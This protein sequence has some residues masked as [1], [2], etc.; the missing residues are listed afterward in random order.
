MNEGLVAAVSDVLSDKGVAWRDS[1]DTDCWRLCIV[2]TYTAFPYAVLYVV[3][4]FNF[5]NVNTNA[6]GKLCARENVV[7]CHV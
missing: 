1:V 4:I 6:C 3:K 5:K 2:T 7:V